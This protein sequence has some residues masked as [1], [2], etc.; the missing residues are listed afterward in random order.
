VSGDGL[1]R[2]AREGSPEAIGELFAR[3][4]AVTGPG[5]VSSAADDLALA[6]ARVEPAWS[7]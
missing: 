3:D 6:G 2:R 5:D 1:V 4:G 7:Q